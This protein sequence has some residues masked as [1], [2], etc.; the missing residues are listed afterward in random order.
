MTTMDFHEAEALTG[1][2][3]GGINPRRLIPSGFP[4]PTAAWQAD[5]WTGS[6]IR[7]VVVLTVSAAASLAMTVTL[8]R[9]SHHPADRPVVIAPVRPELFK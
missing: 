2:G 5:H 6:L 3:A 8:D 1:A 7:V 4:Q 9:S